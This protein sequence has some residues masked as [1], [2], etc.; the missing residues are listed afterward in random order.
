MMCVRSVCVRS[1]W[2]VLLFCIIGGG[3]L[4]YLYSCPVMVDDDPTLWMSDVV[5]GGYEIDVT[6]KISFYILLMFGVENNV[7]LGCVRG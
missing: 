3:V 2:V 1:V 6:D 4:F 5:C 7:D